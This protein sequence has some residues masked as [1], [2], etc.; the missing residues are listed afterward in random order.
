MERRLAGLI[1][2]GGGIRL[3]ADLFEPLDCDVGGEPELRNAGSLVQA[4]R[5]GAPWHIERNF[6]VAPWRVKGADLS[7]AARGQARAIHNRSF[8]VAADDPSMGSG[9]AHARKVDPCLADKPPGKRGYNRAACEPGRT[10]IALRR[11]H[12]AERIEP[13]AGLTLNLGDTFRVVARRSC[14]QSERGYAARPPTFTLPHRG[15]G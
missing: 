12:F 10:V 8:H 14:R 15:G 2:Q 3:F 7:P 9:G 13:D 11:A 6:L 1:R 5:I 4:S